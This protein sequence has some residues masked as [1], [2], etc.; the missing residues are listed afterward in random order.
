MKVKRKPAELVWEQ[1]KKDENLSDLELE[2]FQKYESF[3]RENN[4]DFNLTALTETAGIVRQHFV[5]SLALKRVFDLNK[6][7]AIADIGTGGGFPSI[8]LKI[9]YPHLKVI[10]IEVTKKKQRF[11][12][13]LMDLL[14]LDMVSVCGY[15]WRTFLRIT[16]FDVDLF[17]TK[18]ALAE[19]ELCRA[20]KPSCFY[21]E[22]P[23]VYWVGNPWEP[24]PKVEGFVKKVEPYKLS[25]KHRGLAFLG[26]DE[27]LD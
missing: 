25:R 14:H 4:E 16:D 8:P 13:D 24:D 12:L 18:A 2:K 11:L 26:L 6:V 22:V 5:D 23:I 10:L 19:R 3:L 15:D 17:V 9:L 1:F 7:K 21:N 20:F 27:K